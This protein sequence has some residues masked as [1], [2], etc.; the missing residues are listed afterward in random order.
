[1]HTFK[2]PDG[3]TWVINGGLL[4]GADAE[5]ATW[6]NQRLGGGAVTTLF[7]AIGG[8]RP[9]V[10]PDQVTAETLPQLLCAGA[11]FFN[12]HD[13]DS[14][15]YSDLEWAVAIDDQ[16]VLSRDV[17]RKVLDFPFAQLKVRRLSAEIDLANAKAVDQAKS[18]GFRLEGRK[19]RK[20][21]GG[22]DVGIFGL[23][24]EEVAIR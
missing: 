3:R 1:M 22:G 5:V 2:H 17:V 4:Y 6:V 7:V 24:P 18:L 15:D 16:S 9:G 8:L 23:L 19:R 13:G 21:P 20:A 12:H 10:T 11:Y 14:S